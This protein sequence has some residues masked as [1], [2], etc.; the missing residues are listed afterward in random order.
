M[1]YADLTQCGGTKVLSP[2]GSFSKTLLHDQVNREVLSFLSPYE[3]S[4]RGGKEKRGTKQGDRAKKG[5][6][7][8]C[9]PGLSPR[10]P[11]RGVA[12]ASLRPDPGSQQLSNTFNQQVRS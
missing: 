11:V 5:D 10:L 4:A 12:C 3:L 1:S 2:G 9:P 6:K 7:T 8:F